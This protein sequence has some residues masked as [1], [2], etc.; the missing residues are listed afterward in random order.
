MS[1]GLSRQILKE[2][3][4]FSPERRFKI[5]ARGRNLTSFE[6]A[7]LHSNIR[8]F[9]LDVV[10]IVHAHTPSTTAF[11]SQYRALDINNQDACIFYNDISYAKHYAGFPITPDQGKLISQCLG[12]KK[13]IVLAHHGVATVGESIESALHWFTSLDHC[14]QV[15]LSLLGHIPTGSSGSQLQN[16]AE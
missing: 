2:L 8:N 3:L 9:N 11:N 7:A 4:K 14:R 6:A 16:T 13:A 5:Q 1:V 15:Q 12:S 10:C